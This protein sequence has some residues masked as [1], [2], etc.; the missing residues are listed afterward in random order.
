M[1]DIWALLPLLPSKRQKRL[2]SKMANMDIEI[3]M[4]DIVIISETDESITI[5]VKDERGNLHDNLY[6]EY[7]FLDDRLVFRR[8]MDVELSLWGRI[9]NCF[10]YLFKPYSY[11]AKNSFAETVLSPESIMQ[12]SDFLATVVDDIDTENMVNTDTTNEN[13]MEN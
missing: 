3:S 12:L 9:K 11:S 7:R 8:L 13:D 5:M 10:A 2:E 4:S 6:V 1:T